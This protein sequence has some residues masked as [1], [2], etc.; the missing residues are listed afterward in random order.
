MVGI[1]FNSINFNQMDYQK[2]I[3][4]SRS[5]PK[6]GKRGCLCPNGTYSAKCCDGSLAAQGIGPITGIDRGL[7][8]WNSY[9]VR[10]IAD[11]GVVEGRDCLIRAINKIANITTL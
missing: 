2:Y 3:T 9:S 4:P 8:L 1:G 7:Q 11:G 6:G 5:S 10:V